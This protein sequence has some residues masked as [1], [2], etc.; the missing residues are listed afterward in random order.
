[1]VLAAFSRPLFW[2][3]FCAAVTPS[4]R[5]IF[6]VPALSLAQDTAS[7][8]P[9]EAELRLKASALFASAP[10]SASPLTEVLTWRLGPATFIPAF[11]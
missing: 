11:S 8:V 9:S 2:A 1:M 6:L 10:A 5:A 4:Y 7:E 3:T